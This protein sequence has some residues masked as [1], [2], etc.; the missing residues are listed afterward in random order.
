MKGKTLA[1]AAAQEAYEEAGV[2]GLIDPEPL[3]S[4][5]FHKQHVVLGRVP[6]EILVHCLAVTQELPRWPEYGQR[7][8]RWFSQSQAANQV[9]SREL[10][11][12]ILQ[13]HKRVPIS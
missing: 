10:A 11:E 5:Q 6:V 4:F 13:L 7:E 12:L 2:E 8:R 9:Q 3:G 1:S